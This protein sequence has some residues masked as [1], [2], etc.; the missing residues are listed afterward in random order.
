MGPLI[1]TCLINCSSYD[2]DISMQIM[3]NEYVPIDTCHDRCPSL[4]NSRTA[5]DDND[6]D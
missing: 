1:I 5:V 6:D 3:P 2:D 4:L